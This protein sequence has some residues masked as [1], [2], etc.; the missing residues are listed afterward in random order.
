[1][2][3]TLWITS[4]PDWFICSDHPVALFYT[5]S[6][7]VFVDPMALENPRVELFADSI[8][9]PIAKNVA[10]VMHRLS[11]VPP[12]QPAHQQMVA[13]VNT[14]TI[15]QAQRNIFSCTEDFICRLPSGAIGNARQSIEALQSF[16]AATGSKDPV[17]TLTR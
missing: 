14:M 6:G 8:Y 9:M 12:A 10:L 17:S 16:R 4:G 1:M 11:D 15:M 5:M 2:K 13:L 7:D 3:V